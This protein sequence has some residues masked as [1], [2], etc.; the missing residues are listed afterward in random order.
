[1]NLW[2]KYLRPKTV[3]EA[4][5]GLTSAP[6]PNCPIAGGTDLLL[7]L[8]QGNHPP[9]HTLVDLT[10]ISEMTSLEIRADGLF[11]GAA[12]PLNSIVATDIVQEHAQALIEA[13]Q[14]VAGPQVRNTA[15]LGG[16]VVHALPAADGTIALMVLQAQAEIADQQGR[17]LVP[18]ANLFLGPGKSLINMDRELLVGFHLPLRKGQQASAFRRIMRAQG[19]ALP[20][21][22]VAVWLERKL[23]LIQDVRIAVGPGGPTP[24]RASSAE[25]TL[26]GQPYSQAVIS[27][28]LAALIKQVGFRTSAY[29]AS[30]EYRS[31][32]VGG[33]L[34][35]CLETAWKR[36]EM[37]KQE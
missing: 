37:E 6:G 19:I 7:D 32:L 2:Q 26:R 16:N 20:I 34:K 12:V 22:N 4:L 33:L 5:A 25:D 10:T 3:E 23:D 9:V 14:L 28:G 1:M 18:V 8:K 13:A 17:R 36:A 24:W 29:R 15:T 21:L 11:I 31:H 35:E 30:A 27:S